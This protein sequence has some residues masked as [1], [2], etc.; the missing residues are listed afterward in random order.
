MQLRERKW[1]KFMVLLTGLVTVLAGCSNKAPEKNGYSVYTHG[2][3][4]GPGNSKIVV[5]L[6]DE[7][8]E[9]DVDSVGVKATKSYTK[10]DF[11]AGTL[12]EV[13][14]T[15]PITLRGA[16]LSDVDGN[17]VDAK[18]FYITL[19]L[20]VHPDNTFTNPYNYNFAT[21]FNSNVGIEYEITVKNGDQEVVLTKDDQI[22]V[23][24]PETAVYEKEEF[25]HDD[26]TLTYASYKPSNTDTKRPLVILLHGAGEGGTDP[27]VALLGNKV[28]ALTSESIQKYFEGAFVLVPQTPT[29]WMNDGTGGYTTDGQSMYTESLLALIEDYIANNDDIDTSRVYIGGGSNGGYMTMKMLLAKPELFAAAFPICEAYASDWISDAELE[30]IKSIPIWFVHSKDDTTVTFEPT[31][32]ATYNRLV[33]LGASDVRIT[34]FDNVVD[35]TGEVKN[36]AGEPYQYFGHWSWIYVYNDE[37]KENGVSLYQ[38][39]ADQSK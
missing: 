4:W 33:E 5:T 16:Y 39:L 11:A 25:K 7:V 1:I 20:D 17:K 31:A 32:L 28:V 8:S 21:G 3:D 2:Y 24:V 6:T 14:E 26:I 37:V 19:E 35:T 13:T 38:W 36:A 30:S 29:M 27:E 18:S 34:A 23:I 10:Y 15:Q 12:S 22:S 9:I